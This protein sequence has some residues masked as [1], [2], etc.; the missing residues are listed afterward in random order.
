[1]HLTSMKLQ[2]EYTS[3]YDTFSD[4]LSSYSKIT[5]METNLYFPQSSE[6]ESMKLQVSSIPPVIPAKK[7]TVFP[8]GRK[9]KEIVQILIQCYHMYEGH[10]DER[11]FKDLI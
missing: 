1:M 3:S 11:N 6:N 5:E 4:S 7:I 8:K 2:S 9:S 10:W